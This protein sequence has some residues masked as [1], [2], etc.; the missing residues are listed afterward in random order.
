MSVTEKPEPQGDKGGKKFFLNIEGV[1]H[2]WDKPTVTAAQIAQLGGWDLAQ[3]V[4]EIDADNVEH[5]LAPDAVV[6]LKPGH[7]FAKKIKWQRGDTVF[8]GRLDEEL[9]LIRS[10]FPDATRV[11]PW[12]HLGTV[13]IPGAGWNRETTEVVIRAPQG[14]PGST[15]YG[16]YVP[17]GIQVNG[18]TPGNYT[19]P[20]SEAPPFQGQWGVFS[21]QSDNGIWKPGATPAEG[22]NLLNFALGTL[23]RLQQGK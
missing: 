10:R 15:P 11:G 4:I 22:S 6:D 18:S 23:V 14:Y 16:V 7:G 21:W 9:L 20:A 13:K 5:Q 2:P 3:G 19:E 12:Y 1:E 17:S 8:E